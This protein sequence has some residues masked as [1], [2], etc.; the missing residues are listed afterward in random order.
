M[1]QL[2]A[3]RAAPRRRVLFGAL[4]A[5]GWSWATVKALFWFV[6][7]LVVLAYIPDR[8]Y[9]FTVNRTLDIGLLAWS[10]VN[11]CPAENQELPCPAPLGAILPWE[12]SPAE[13]GLPAPRRDGAVAQLGTRILYI[14]GTDGTAAQA[15]T[16]VAN[17]KDGNYGAWSD[18]PALPEPRSDVAVTVISGVVYVIGGADADGKPT[19]TVWTLSADQKTGALSGWAPA[20]GL[21]LPAA[22]SAAVAVG[23][24]DGIVVVGGLDGSGKPTSTVWKSTQ[25]LKGELG[26][27]TDGA[28][29]LD[30]IADASAAQVGDFLWV[31]GGTD[32]NGPS[33]A[34]QRGA[35]GT[36]I[37]VIEGEI[38]PPGTE[39]DPIKVLQW[40]VVNE[41]NLPVARTAAAGFSA[42]GVLYLVGGTDGDAIRSELHWAVPTATG[43]LPGWSHLDVMDLPPGGLEGAAAFT[44][45]SNAFLIGGAT[46]DGIVSGAA[47]ANLAPQA[48]FFQVGIAGIVIPA[49]QIPG[50]VGQQL[51][52]LAADGMATVNFIILLGVAWMFAHKP[53]VAAWW[54]KR[55]GRAR[56]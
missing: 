4:D 6:V 25:N 38:K 14:G 42:N 2:P 45:G 20:T 10:P 23:I 31:Y 9:Y 46:E 36:G 16:F 19:T 22:R 28:P 49:L 39:P 30:P 48:P 51:G 55:R 18:G 33:G 5:D 54:A 26:A 34:V 27:F 52:Y 56:P 12:P 29:L 1:T 17:L 40:G 43:E 41:V 32:P 21:T 47:R 37:K 53:Q 50:E 11:L 24:S 8:A 35:L 13:I 15:T 44:S 3:G 7:M